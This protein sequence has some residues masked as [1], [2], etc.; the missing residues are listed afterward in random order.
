MRDIW[1]EPCAAWSNRW[2]EYVLPPACWIQKP[3]PDT[4]LP[5]NLSP[6]ALLFGSKSHD[7]RDI[8]PPTWSTLSQ[9]E[10]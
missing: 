8:L 3:L 7:S 4:S 6:L 1:W 10:T 2:G 9:V 5:G